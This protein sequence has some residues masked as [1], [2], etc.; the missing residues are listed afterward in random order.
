MIVFCEQGFFSADEMKRICEAGI[1]YNLKPKLHVNQLN[2]IGG[3]EAAIELNALS[4][5]HL[6]TMNDEEINK[7]SN[8]KT[9]ATLS[10][11]CCLFFKNELSACKKIN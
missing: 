10:A 4:V 5:D 1:K 8:S 2:S 11:N 3:I 6:E 9:I 7:L